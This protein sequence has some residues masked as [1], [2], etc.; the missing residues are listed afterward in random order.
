MS[1]AVLAGAVILLLAATMHVE[2]ARLR[3]DHVPDNVSAHLGL[4][5]R[6]AKVYS[7]VKVT[8]AAER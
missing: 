7:D 1:K 2:G 3:C 5:C 6:V 8:G 4:Y